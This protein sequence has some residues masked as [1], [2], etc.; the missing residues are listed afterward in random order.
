MCFK[1][2][3]NLITYSLVWSSEE[4]Q[5]ADVQRF[6]STR[7]TG[8]TLA[9]CTCSGYGTYLHQT[10]A[11]KNSDSCHSNI[12]WLEWGPCTSSPRQYYNYIDKDSKAS[13]NPRFSNK[14]QKMNENLSIKLQNRFI[15]WYRYSLEF[16]FHRQL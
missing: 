9:G 7:S 12:C 11:A 1:Y 15:R 6:V 3:L 10:P 13:R 4:E 16:L 5:L 14:R 8:F 2:Q